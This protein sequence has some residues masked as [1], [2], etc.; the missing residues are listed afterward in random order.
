MQV[1]PLQQPPAQVVPLHGEGTQLP[2]GLHI[3]VAPQ[4]EQAT[5]ELPH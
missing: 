2:L 5:P 1:L 3:S 4:G